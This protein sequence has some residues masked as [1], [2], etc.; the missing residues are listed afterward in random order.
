MSFFKF[1]IYALI[2]SF[3]L[4]FSSCYSFNIC[5]LNM[6]SHLLSGS[7]MNSGFVSS[8]SFALV[9][10]AYPV[11]FLNSLRASSLT[12]RFSSFTSTFWNSS[13]IAKSFSLSYLKSPQPLPSGPVGLYSLF[14]HLSLAIS[15]SSRPSYSGLFSS[16]SASPSCG[17]SKYSFGILY[18]LTWSTNMVRP[19]SS[20]PFK[21]STAR[22][23]DL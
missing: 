16:S 20:I 17:G 2:S 18:C 15:S 14:S 10:T 12:L 21:L 6:A 19:Q 4:C 8:G 9:A 23:V 7:K 3:Y 22:F 5:Y 1:S 13:S 11:S